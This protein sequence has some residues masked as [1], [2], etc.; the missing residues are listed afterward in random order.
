MDEKD[1]EIYRQ[2]LEETVKDLV[3]GGDTVLVEHIRSISSLETVIS[4]TVNGR[5]YLLK[6]VVSLA[7]IYLTRA[8]LR[9]I[10]TM[11]LNSKRWHDVPKNNPEGEK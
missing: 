7:D 6:F 2:R 4:R 11:T 9:D 3:E 5:I 10:V 8:S 1:I